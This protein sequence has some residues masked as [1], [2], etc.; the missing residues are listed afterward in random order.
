VPA[1]RSLMRKRDSL[2]R[3]SWLAPKLNAASR[4][5]PAISLMWL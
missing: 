5:I 2:S 1:S 4:E 3:I